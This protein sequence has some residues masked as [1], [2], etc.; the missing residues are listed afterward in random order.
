MWCRDSGLVDVDRRKC[1]DLDLVSAIERRFSDEIAES[2]KQ[3]D[4]LATINSSLIE[5]GEKYSEAG[6]RLKRTEGEKKALEVRLDCFFSKKSARRCFKRP[7]PP[8]T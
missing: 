3:I 6:S 8:L 2:K 7:L 5:D 4:D 1:E